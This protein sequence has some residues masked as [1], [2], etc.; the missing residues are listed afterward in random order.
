M[1]D[2][3][4]EK[5]AVGALKARTLATFSPGLKSPRVPV[6]KNGHAPFQ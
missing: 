5:G 2:D 1:V 3:F 4:R 6:R